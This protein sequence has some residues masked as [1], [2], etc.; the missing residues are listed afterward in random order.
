[1]FGFGKKE[2]ATA[3]TAAV[4]DVDAEANAPRKGWKE[5]MMPVFACGSGLFS[6]GYIN[7][8]HIPSSILLLSFKL[9]PCRSL[10][11]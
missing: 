3:T 6:D 11:P 9:T 10:A 1:M 7:N 2:E 4:V 8:V 5:A